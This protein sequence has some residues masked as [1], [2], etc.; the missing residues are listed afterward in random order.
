LKIFARPTVIAPTS[1]TA[2]ILEPR[3]A[4]ADGG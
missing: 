3:A 2:K 4:H 1:M